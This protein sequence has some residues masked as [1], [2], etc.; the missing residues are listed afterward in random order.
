MGDSLPRMPIN[1]RAKFDAAIF[2]LGGEIRNR[3]NTETHKKQ[4]KQTYPHLAYRHV[5]IT[6]ETDA[7]KLDWIDDEC[8]ASPA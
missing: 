2:I 4:Q 8:M 1:H 6:S 7:W 5:W 3:T